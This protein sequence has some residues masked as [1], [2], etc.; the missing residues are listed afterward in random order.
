M[1][2]IM[3]SQAFM[4]SVIYRRA[5]RLPAGAPRLNQKEMSMS[6][7]FTRALSAVLAATSAAYA[8]E[9]KHHAEVRNSIASYS[10]TK[11]LDGATLWFADRFASVYYTVEADT[12]EVVTTIVE[13]SGRRRP[14]QTRLRLGDGETKTLSIG[15]YGPDA[16][17][18]TLN[19]TRAGDELK[20]RVDAEGGSE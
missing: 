1:M 19:L 7:R 9:P 6:R 17:L 4:M 15:G 18:A 8:D 11:P 14:L 13:R 20:L 12:F 5:A 16:P 2:R 10:L 3:Y